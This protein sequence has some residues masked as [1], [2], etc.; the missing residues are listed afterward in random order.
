MVSTGSGAGVCAAAADE[1]TNR[2]NQTFLTTPPW[3]IFF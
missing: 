1:K 3:S 2:P